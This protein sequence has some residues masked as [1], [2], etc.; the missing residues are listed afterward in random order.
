MYTRIFGP[1]SGR[2]RFFPDLQQITYFQSKW[3]TNT[4]HD[5]QLNAFKNRRQDPQ[6]GISRALK[7]RDHA[8]DRPYDGDVCFELKF[9]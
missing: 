8:P 2:P 4:R 6:E 3:N 1:P 5:M 9:D 7:A